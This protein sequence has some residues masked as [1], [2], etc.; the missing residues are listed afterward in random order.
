MKP[1]ELEE[2]CP[3]CKQA[4]LVLA[5]ACCSDRSKGWSVVKKCPKC[6]HRER[7]L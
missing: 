1:T 4:N 7:V 6:G 3:S 5:E 2:K